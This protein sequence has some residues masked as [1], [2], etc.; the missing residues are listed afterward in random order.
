MLDLVERQAPEPGGQLAG[1]ALREPPLSQQPLAEKGHDIEDLGLVGEVTDV[2]TSFLDLLLNNGIMPVIAPIGVNDAGEPY[3]VNADIAAASVAEAL[4]AEKLVY[5]SDVQGVIINDSLV[6][7][8]DEAEAEKLIVS[9]D[10]NHG[11]IPKIRSAYRALASGVHKVHMIDG[12]V[13]HSLLL[14]IFTDE[15]VG[16][17]LVHTAHQ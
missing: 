8:M 1:V 14:E 17:Q 3:N 4:K 15:G 7:S 11:M 6:H 12:R 5:L 13:R 16:T 2:N 10:I 9:R